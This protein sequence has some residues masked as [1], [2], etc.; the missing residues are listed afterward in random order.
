MNN[1]ALFCRLALLDRN[2]DQV[3]SFN[4]EQELWDISKLLQTKPPDIQFNASPSE[5]PSSNGHQFNSHHQSRSNPFT[6]R[7]L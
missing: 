6:G 7:S 1:D 4:L 2:K 3:N 5:V